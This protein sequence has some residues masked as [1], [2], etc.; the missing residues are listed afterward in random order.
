MSVESKKRMGKKQ[1]AQNDCIVLLPP[2][3]QYSVVKVSSISMIYFVEWINV[4][5]CSWVMLC[6]KG[7]KRMVMVLFSLIFGLSNDMQ[8]A[9]LRASI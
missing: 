4:K 5:E 9:T 6:G 7:I 1:R 8:F 3:R 2:I